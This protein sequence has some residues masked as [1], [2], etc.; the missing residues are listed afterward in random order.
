MGC[1]I[2]TVREIG[3]YKT[4]KRCSLHGIAFVQDF[5]TGQGHSAH[6][7]VSASGNPAVVYGKDARIVR[8]HGWAYNTD[9]ISVSDTLDDI[10]RQEC[11]CGGTHGERPAAD[12]ERGAVVQAIDAAIK[13]HIETISAAPHKVA[14]EWAHGAL[15]AV[16]D[17]RAELLGSRW[18][19]FEQ[20]GPKS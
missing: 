2:D 16:R 13:L 3:P 9:R 5:T 14:E 19:E 17:L 1:K 11:R 10:A 7:N 15:N 20:G 6:P 12:L 18:T 8:C 4:L